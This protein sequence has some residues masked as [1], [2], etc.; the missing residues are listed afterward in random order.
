MTLPF[1]ATS[2]NA[3]GFSSA[4]R[5]FRRKK[6]VVGPLKYYEQSGVN[7]GGK[8]LNRREALFGFGVLALSSAARTQEHPAS[9]DDELRKLGEAF[10]FFRARNAKDYA[11]AATSGIEEAKYLKVGDIEQWV[12]IR[13]EDRSNPVVLVLHGGPGDATNPWGYA[14]FRTWLKTYTV[15]QWDQRGAGKT[16]GRNGRASAE[17]VTIDRLVQDGVELAD[18]LCTSLRKGQTPHR[19]HV[20]VRLECTRVQGSR[21]A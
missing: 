16:L 18:T 3:R 17:T 20:G 8:M 2:P 9:N 1:W 6:T 10:D 5:H 11:I 4:S 13:G 21:H 12:T 19:E 15:V 14:G 7:G